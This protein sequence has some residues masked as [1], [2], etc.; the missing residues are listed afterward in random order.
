MQ[1]QDQFSSKN[2]QIHEAAIHS[3][4]L[5]YN[6]TGAKSATDTNGASTDLFNKL[7]N[8]NSKN[9]ALR[10]AQD[11]TSDIDREFNGHHHQPH[12]ND[13]SVDVSN[14][15]SQFR[16][17]TSNPKL[18][19]LSKEPNLVHDSSNLSSSSSSA[20]VAANNLN[21]NNP[22]NTNSEIHIL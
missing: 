3:K 2:N 7:Y 22:A 1:Q 9:E 16:L 5:N 4:P 8:L 10:A 14:L 18:A 20:T 15:I 6:V 21:N 17:A 12:N 13:D 11:E 19:S